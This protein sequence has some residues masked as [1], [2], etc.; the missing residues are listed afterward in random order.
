M[1]VRVA[2]LTNFDEEIEIPESTNIGDLKA[3]VSA[4]FGFDPNRVLVFSTDHLEHPDS[5]VIL[6]DPSLSPPFYVFYDQKVYGEKS[7]P[8]VEGAFPFPPTRFG[9][10]PVRHLPEFG[11]GWQRNYLIDPINR[12]RF[13][14]P[15]G[16]SDSEQELDGSEMD[17]DDLRAVPHPLSGLPLL[18]YARSI[19]DGPPEGFPDLYIDDPREDS[20]EEEPI[21]TGVEIRF[22]GVTVVLQPD[23]AERVERLAGLGFDPAIV[24][25]V[26]EACGRDENLTQQCLLDGGFR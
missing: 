22:G 14:P 8:S 15:S 13:R 26:Y 9:K 10:L 20:D 2:D 23:D 21:M 1:R 5:E 6:A 24:A 25:Q 12:L 11:M 18:L 19:E 16:S 17:I 4:R 3:I 7:Y